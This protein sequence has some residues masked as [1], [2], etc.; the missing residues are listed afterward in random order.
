[1]NSDGVRRVS[2]IVLFASLQLDFAGSA[3]A[4]SIPDDLV[5]SLSY[6]VVGTISPSC[7]LSQPTRA[8]EVVG[9]QN[10]DTDTVQA[11][12]TDLPFTVACTTPVKVAMISAHGG[13]L[14][15]S[16]SPDTDFTSRVGYRATLDLPGASAALE[17]RSDDMASGAAGCVR[18]IQDGA[19]DGD[20]RIR[21]HTD[22][23][24]DLLLAGT[25]RDT[26]TLTISP[27]LSGDGN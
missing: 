16:L 10:P 21:I 3:R 12:D 18:E 11:T 27:Q 20:G 19:I 14:T 6:R 17:C 4:A 26:V 1:M 22:P 24:G 23:S 25:Y 13:L 15:D 9:L 7:S 5:P 8:V 2:A